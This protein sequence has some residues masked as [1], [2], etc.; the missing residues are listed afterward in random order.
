MVCLHLTTSKSSTKSSQCRLISST[1]FSSTAFD[2]FYA[3]LHCFLGGSACSRRITT[4]LASRATFLHIVA[5]HAVQL[6]L[7]F[8]LPNPCSLGLAASLPRSHTRVHAIWAY[9][10]PGRTIRARANRASSA[11]RARSAQHLHTPPASAVL[12]RARSRHLL[13]VTHVPLL[14][15]SRTAPV[16]RLPTHAC[17]LEPPAL[18]STRARAC[19]GRRF[20]SG[21]ARPCTPCPYTPHRARVVCRPCSAGPEPRQLPA[22]SLTGSVHT[23]RLGRSCSAALTHAP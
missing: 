21:A 10:C 15:R 18:C 23:V 1:A 7:R 16:L 4:P 9:S 22:S 17:R 20:R 3:R 14:H 19:C 13:G 5:L 6:L 11:L 12:P 2:V 8:Q